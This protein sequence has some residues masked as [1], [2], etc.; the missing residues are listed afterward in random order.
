[1]TTRRKP[2]G[3]CYHK[4]RQVACERGHP[5]TPDNTYTYF[6]SD[7]GLHRQCRKCNRWRKRE[8]YRQH[9]TRIRGRSDHV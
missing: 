9:Q 7:G 3:I 5:F 4:A 1:M 2:R 8:A 6:D